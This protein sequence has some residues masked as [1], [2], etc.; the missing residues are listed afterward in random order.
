M[1]VKEPVTAVMAMMSTGMGRRTGVATTR[2]GEA[3]NTATGVV[4][5]IIPAKHAVIEAGITTI[6]LT[7]LIT[8]TGTE[9]ATGTDWL[10]GNESTWGEEWGSVKAVRS[11]SANGLVV[12]HGACLG[13]CAGGGF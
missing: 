10:P 2:E 3:E 5:T 4:T 13:S 12:D 6:P 7:I 9:T 11:K 1:S 8:A